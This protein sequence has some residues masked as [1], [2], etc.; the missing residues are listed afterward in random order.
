MAH[1]PVCN[2]PTAETKLGLGQLERIAEQPLVQL[3]RPVMSVLPPG[4]RDPQTSWR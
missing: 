3:A 2:G 1:R 4:E